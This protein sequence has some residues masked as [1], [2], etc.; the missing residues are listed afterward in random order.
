MLLREL[1]K[2]GARGVGR[3][4]LFNTYFLVGI[5]ALF[6]VFAL[7]GHSGIEPAK[8][9]HR[10]HW[11]ISSKCKHYSMLQELGPGIG[12]GGPLRSET[13]LR[14]VHIRQQVAGLHRGD[15]LQLPEPENLLWRRHLRVLDTETIVA[16][17]TSALYLAY[18]GR[19]L[20]LGEG[21]ERQLHSFVSNRVKAELISGE[22]PFLRHRIQFVSFVLRQ[23][24]V[25]WIV[26]VRFQQS[27]GLR[28]Q[29]A[30]HESFQHTGVQHVVRSGMRTPFAIQTLDGI[31]EWQPL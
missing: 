22:H 25:F 20:R 16:P 13:R 31:I 15:N 30:V 5:V 1:G 18:L 9:R 24:R 14:P 2:G 17:A 29:R 28:S 4:S 23:T 7:P 6:L 21:I 19:F 8:R 3:D 27:R 11:I 10:L 26:A 12:M